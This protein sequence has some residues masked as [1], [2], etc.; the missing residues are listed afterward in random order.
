ML[1][2]GRE[3]FSQLGFFKLFTDSAT[4]TIK[5]EIT[6]ANKKYAASKDAT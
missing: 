5:N 6:I 3:K 4:S 1:I 2:L